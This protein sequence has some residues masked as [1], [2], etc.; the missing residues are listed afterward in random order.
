MLIVIFLFI[1]L[2]IAFQLI[3]RKK[4]LED[5]FDEIKSVLIEN[6]IDLQDI[7]FDE[8]TLNSLL[9]PLSKNNNLAYKIISNKLEEPYEIVSPTCLDAN[10]MLFFASKGKDKSFWNKNVEYSK[11]GSDPIIKSSAIWAINSIESNNKD[12]FN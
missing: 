5:E 1:I 8:S 6:N 11:I 7:N 4:S 2:F 3:F 9:T 10:F 12:F